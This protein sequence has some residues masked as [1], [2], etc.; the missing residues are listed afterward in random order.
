MNRALSITL[1]L[2]GL[3]AACAGNDDGGHDATVGTTAASTGMSTPVS[4]SSTS[5]AETT[6]TG[7]GTDS[8]TGSGSGTA[9]GTA[10]TT[11][12]TT[13]TAG[14]TTAGTTTAGTTTAGT[15]TAGTTTSGGGCVEPPFD[16]DPPGRSEIMCSSDPECGP[17]KYCY[18]IPLLGGVCGECLEDAHCPGGGCTPPN[19]L[20]STGA[21]C[22]TGKPGAGCESDA[23]CESACHTHCSVALDASPILEVS[24]CGA[25][26]T[27]DECPDGAICTPK[28]D[29][30][31]FSGVNECVPVGTLGDGESCSLAGDGG[32]ACASGRCASAVLM[33]IIEIG[34]CSECAF[35]DD[36]APG[37]FCTEAAVD[38]ETFALIPSVCQ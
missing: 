11:G 37:E 3:L 9:T 4:V 32:Q 25:C 29:V 24:T 22:N 30:S 34:V 23:V 36:C 10:G 33:T 18:I 17:D 27:S 19:P 14:T 8:D 2:A 5:S 13:T 35:D 28:V 6:G 7:P 16:P 31:S 20:L 26:S 12:E 38:P 15:T 21:I 1:L